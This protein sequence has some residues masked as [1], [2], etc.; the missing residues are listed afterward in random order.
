M[1]YQVASTFVVSSPIS[2]ASVPSVPLDPFFTLTEIL[3]KQFEK[4]SDEI[5]NLPSSRQP[6]SRSNQRNTHYCGRSRSRSNNGQ[7]YYHQRF[8]NN[9]KKC[10]KPCSWK[11]PSTSEN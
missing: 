3:T 5:P 2:K 6:R 7:C 8:S 4:L 11:V 1:S 10:A 9:A